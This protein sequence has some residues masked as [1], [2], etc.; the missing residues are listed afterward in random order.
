[1]GQNTKTKSDKRLTKR[2]SSMEKH[3]QGGQRKRYK[4]TLKASMKDFDIP[5]GRRE[6]KA[7]NKGPPADSIYLQLELAKSVIELTHFMK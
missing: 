4:E 2:K 3:S 5:M 6:R 1:M 7:K